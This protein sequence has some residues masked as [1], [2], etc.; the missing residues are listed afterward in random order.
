MRTAT[1]LAAGLAWTSAAYAQPQDDVDAQRFRPAATSGGFVTV[2]SGGVRDPV[3]PW[4]FGLW[5]HYAN[6]PLVF[7]GTD[8][9]VE[10]RIVEHQ[11]G[12]DATFSWA[13]AS[14]FELGVDLPLGLQFGDDPRGGDVSTGTL[15]DLRLVPKFGLLSDRADGIGLA[16]I[17]ELRVPTHLGDFA[18]GTRIPVFAPRLALDHR[19]GRTGFRAGTNVGVVV[20]EATDLGNVHAGTELSAS[21][22]LGYRFDGG[23][24]PVEI[25]AEGISGIG[26]TETDPEETALEA[27]L[28]VRFDPTPDWAITGGGG[29]GILEGYG[30]P[31]FR[32]FLGLR[33]EPSAHD[34]DRDGI[35]DE[36][37]TCP[38][39]PEDLDGAEDEDGCPEGDD[40]HDGVLD[41]DDDCPDAAEVINGF[42]DEDGCPDEGPA[43]VVVEEGRLTILENIRFETNSDR[44][45][46]ESRGILDQ[47]VLTMRAHEEIR[48]VRIEGHTDSTGSRDHNVRLSRRRAEAVRRYLVQHGIGGGRVEAEGYG[49]DRPIES[50]DSESGRS[51]NRRVEFVIP[52]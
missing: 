9:D 14:W 7:V 48:R 43:R 22:A 20:R 4:S 2:E 52:P 31:L 47:I 3:D 12:V 6:S 28:G 26:L 49:P 32:V 21:L 40:D 36:R 8:D 24:A 42:E 19:F 15:G 11:L 38:D 51:R 10:Q 39:L 25:L 34:Q 5:M 1:L 18:G 13:F 29:M 16:V 45:A 30:V 33:W 27:L 44:I 50:N 46:P 37:D 35:P 17:P 23:R 41:L